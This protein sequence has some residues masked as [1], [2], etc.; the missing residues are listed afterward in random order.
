[1]L[2]LLH[3]VLPL[4]L[5]ALALGVMGPLGQLDRVSA[6]W[7]I[8]GSLGLALIFTMLSQAWPTRLGV[9]FIGQTVLVGLAHWLL[10]PPPPGAGPALLLAF[11][12]FVPGA[13]AAALLRWSVIRH[14]SR[15]GGEDPPPPV[16]DKTARVIGVAVALGCLIGAVGLARQAIGLA[17]TA[18]P[19]QAARG[20]VAVD[21]PGQALSAP[22][23]DRVL[24]DPAGIAR[25]LIDVEITN[26]S[27]FILTLIEIEAVVE[28][29]SGI[30]RGRAYFRLTAPLMPLAPDGRITAQLALPPTLSA[31][32]AR[33]GHDLRLRTSFARGEM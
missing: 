13:I 2:R 12:A 29:G 28:D 8:L 22:V 24:V 17:D 33:E 5:S 4:L 30:G 7:L 14:L 31:T 32:L 10:P 23:M 11:G 20:V 26:T 16:T 27:D 1:M 3:P 21:G 9:T 6:V 25:G 19:I 18:Q 15:S